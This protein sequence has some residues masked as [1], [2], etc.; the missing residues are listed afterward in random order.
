M[1]LYNKDGVIHESHSSCKEVSLSS[2]ISFWCWR[3]KLNTC[4]LII[5]YQ[6]R[7][8]DNR[9]WWLTRLLIEVV[10]VFLHTKPATTTAIIASIRLVRNC[11]DERSPWLPKGPWIENRVHYWWCLWW[12]M[13][14]KEAG[15]LR[16]S[17]PDYLD[18]IVALTCFLCKRLYWHR[19]E[20][21]I[22]VICS[23]IIYLCRSWLWRLGPTVW[24]LSQHSHWITLSIWWQW[25]LRLLWWIRLLGYNLLCLDD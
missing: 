11:P 10:Y 12:R 6:I 15:L 3:E 13:A 2:F 18:I 22:I 7:R 9:A 14:S 25:I 4:T 8:S 1:K 24:P 16:G 23:L 21:W 20:Y 5:R 17:L 19:L